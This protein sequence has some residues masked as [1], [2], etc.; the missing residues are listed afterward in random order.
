MEARC[1]DRKTSQDAAGVIRAETGG[2]NQFAFF[3]GGG[4]HSWHTPNVLYLM[5][6][7]RLDARLQH[8]N[9]DIKTAAEKAGLPLDDLKN[10][11]FRDL[12]TQGNPGNWT[13]EGQI[14]GVNLKVGS[15]RTNRGIVYEVLLNGNPL[16]SPEKDTVFRAVD[17]YLRSDKRINAEH[18]DAVY[19]QAGEENKEFDRQRDPYNVSVLPLYARLFGKKAE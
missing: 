11:Q 6:M 2:D 1:S 5:A 14:N 18:V 16:R 4:R 8:R 13:A 3:S 12:N 17:E 19:D 10:L 7:E 9:E 15:N